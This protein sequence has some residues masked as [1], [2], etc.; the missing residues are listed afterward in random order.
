MKKITGI[1]FIGTQRSGSNLLRVMLD[2][3]P[4][5]AAPHP[6]HLLHTF[7]PL[8][9]EYGPLTQHS[10]KQL[11]RDMTDY[12]KCNPVP[13]DGIELN[14]DQI[15]NHSGRFHIFEAFRLIYEESALHKKASYWCCKSMQNLYYVDALE[16]FGLALKLI[17]LYRDGRD[18]ALSFK[19][20]IVG[21]K[22][23]Y[24]LAK[25]WKEEQ[26]VC[27]GLLRKYGRQKI[28]LLSYEELISDPEACIHDLCDFLRIS[29]YPD[30]M[31]FYTS[32]A[33]HD[34][35]AAGEM[36]KNVEKPVIKNNTQKFLKELSPLEIELFEWVAQDTLNALGYPLYSSLSN[37]SLIAEE[38]ISAYNEENI[39]LKRISLQNAPQH[40]KEKR[41]PQKE[42]LNTIRKKLKSSVS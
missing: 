25:Q 31:N 9:P 21:E 12:V 18:V 1:Q 7:T 13:W 11:V 8:L 34:T 41:K 16:Q 37:P 38:A 30:M 10:Y 27:L 35:A 22:H 33:S 23:I 28:F 36:W 24:H 17:F 29:Y 14:P 15:I 2:Q 4:E 26:D 3:H 5:I 40:D 6:P 20:A 39:A 19:K 32:K 42:L